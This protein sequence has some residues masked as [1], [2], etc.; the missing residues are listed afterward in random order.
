[1]NISIN[2]FQQ[3]YLADDTATEK[4]FVQLFSDEVL[5]TAIHPVFQGNNVVLSGPQGCGKTMVLNLLRPEIRVAYWEAGE[6][7][8][9]PKDLRN[10]VSAGINLTRSGITELVQVTLGGGLDQDIR[11]LPLYFGDFFNHL[12]VKDLIDTIEKMTANEEAFDAMVDPTALTKFVTILAAQSCWSGTLVGV[13]TLEQLKGRLNDRINVYRDWVNGN[14]SEPTP[15]DSIRDSKT[16]IGEPISRT[17]DAFRE[18]GVIKTE[19]PVLIR[20]DQIEELHRAFTD[21]QSNLLLSFRKVINRVFYLRDERVNYRAG[22]RR[23]GWD[24]PEFLT[25][26]GSESRLENRRNY[27]KI[28]MDT[29]LF[30][31]GE[32]NSRKKNSVFERFMIDAFQRRV[33]FFYDQDE[34]VG[35]LPEAMARSVFG[36]SPNAEGRLIQLRKKLNDQQIDRALGLDLASDGG[37]WTDEWRSFLREKFR[38]GLP[39]MVDATLAAAWGRQTGG[40]HFKNQHRENPPPEN[41]PWRSR[42]WWRKERLDHAVLQLSVRCQQRFVWWGFDDIKSLSG[43]NITVFLHVCHRIWDG[44]LKNE[45]SLSPEER[46]ELFEG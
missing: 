23:Y 41:E 37:G 4:S 39:G 40:A 18:A 1:M 22:T 29:E 25:V 20:I 2:P 3:L 26:W 6:E 36:G 9:V 45:S 43:G 46:S 7:F 21:R 42:N 28:E 44:F 5:Q 24:T 19:A 8:P 10:F 34:T 11:E 38:S 35:E 16:A 12:I 30:L 33:S 27:Q 31:L 32:A 13:E 15:P 14:L 17:A